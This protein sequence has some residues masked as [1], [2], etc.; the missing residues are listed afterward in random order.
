[1]SAA[2]LAAL[3]HDLVSLRQALEQEDYGSAG[4]VLARHDRRLREFV[5]TTG[6]QSPIQALRGMLQLQHLV[7]GD[8][9]GIPGGS[10]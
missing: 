1:M 3:L 6:A 4:D 10:A 9:G 8:D 2:S 5:Q 7:Q